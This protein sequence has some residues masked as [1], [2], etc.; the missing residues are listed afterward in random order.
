MNLMLFDAD[1]IDEQTRMA[2]RSAGIVRPKAITE[3]L[4]RVGQPHH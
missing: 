4:A 1:L 2:W 3:Q